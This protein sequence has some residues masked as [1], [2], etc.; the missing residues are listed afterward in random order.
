MSKE[1]VKGKILKDGKEQYLSAQDYGL[2]SL[3]DKGFIKEILKGE[4][5][6][7]GEYDKKM[8]KLWPKEFVPKKLSWRNR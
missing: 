1:K 8:R 3:G 2:L 7:E 5:L 4:G 6:D